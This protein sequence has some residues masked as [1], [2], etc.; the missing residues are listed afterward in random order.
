MQQLARELA[1]ELRHA[2]LGQGAVGD[3]HTFVVGH[4]LLSVADVE[5]DTPQ[6]IGLFTERLDPQHPHT[7]TE[8][9]TQLEVVGKRVEILQ[10][11]TVAGVVGHVVGHGEFAELG[12]AFAGDQVG[13]LVHRGARVA[14]VP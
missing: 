4:L 8:V 13:R 12:G 11:L 14:N 5:R 3:N 10:Q 1:L 6:G 2:G 7:K 9:F